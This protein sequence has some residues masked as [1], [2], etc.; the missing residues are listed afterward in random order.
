MKKILIL[1]IYDEGV[2]ANIII[3]FLFFGRLN[4]DQAR[5]KTVI[6]LNVRNWAHLSKISTVC[7]LYMVLQ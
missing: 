3:L 5:G 7:F 4:Q 1:L 6:Q 2:Y